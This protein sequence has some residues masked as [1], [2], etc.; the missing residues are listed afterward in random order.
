ML[1]TG[2]YSMENTRKSTEEIISFNLR[3]MLS[4]R[5]MGVFLTCD[6]E[7]INQ[8]SMSSHLTR[9]EALEKEDRID[10]M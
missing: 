1:I 8:S 10:E 9:D 4:F 5:T 7:F 3:P 6:T 2:W